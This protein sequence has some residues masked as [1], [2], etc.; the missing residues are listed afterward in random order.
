MKKIRILLL[1]A[2]PWRNDDGGGNT[3]CNFFDGMNAEFAQV[4]CSSKMPKNHTC[5]HYYQMTDQMAVKSFL[6]RKPYGQILDLSG[7]NDIADSLDAV[8]EGLVGK[9][10]KVKTELFQFLKEIAWRYSNWKTDALKNFILD[11]DPDVIYAPCYASTF[12]LALTR[13][14]KKLTGCK[15][16]TWSADDTYSLRQISFSP[17]FWLRRFW[18]RH[19]LRKTYPCYDTFYSISEDEADAMTGVVGQRIKILRKTVPDELLYRERPVNQP[20]RMVYAGGIYLSRWKVLAQIGEAL[21]R[22]NQNCVRCVL[23]IYTQNSLNE[24]Q[25]V[26][27]QDGVNIFY[28]QAVSSAELSEIYEKS[29]IALHV[30]SQKWKQKLQTRISFSTK[31]IDCLSS[32]CAVMAI[33][34]KEQTGLKYLQKNGAA[35]C[36][37]DERK[38]EATLRDLLDH[39]ETIREYAQKAYLLAIAKHRKSKIQD[40]LYQ[41]FCELSKSN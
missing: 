28:H 18:N 19:C 37:T 27:L 38:I 3:L 13:W 15:V 16:V 24:K 17:F 21:K 20:V 12:M 9:L 41:T 36:V 26:A 1:V 2:E 25:K 33:A 4:Y 5:Q 39:P 31:I 11:F 40:D 14:V 23:H 22:I 34:W 29:D 30:E 32:G 10:K 8:S 35:I 7:E 6:N